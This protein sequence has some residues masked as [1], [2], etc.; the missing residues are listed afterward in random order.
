MHLIFTRDVL[1]H[2]K[3]KTGFIGDDKK[4]FL[5]VILISLFFSLAF[6]YFSILKYF[7]LDS[8]A[9]DLGIHSQ[10]LWSTLHGHMFY[11]PLIG[12]N[13][14]AEHFAPFE[15]V[16]L[17]I[18]LIYPSPISILIFQAVFV[19][20]AA[21]PLYLVSKY[22]MGMG[23]D[24][25]S[26]NLISLALVISFEMSPYVQSP[27]S[28]DFHNI[29]F[30]PFFFFMAIYSFFRR[31]GFL[32]IT[33]LAFIVSLHSNFVYI[34]GSIIL[35]EFIYLRT[36][37]GTDMKSWA[38]R[39]SNKLFIWQISILAAAIA[40]LY[41]YLVF[42]GIMK[43]YFSGSG[44]YSF[45]PSTGETGSPSTSVLG[46]LA[47]VFK[48]PVELF[49][50][51]SSNY[52]YKLFFI[53]FIF[54]LLGMTPFFAP[55]SLITAL[56]YLMYAVPS[57]YASYYELGYQYTGMFVG[58]V[59]LAA[60]FGI[61]NLLK[62]LKFRSVRNRDICSIR[63]KSFTL[64]FII[65][66]AAT[67]SLPLGL[68]PPPHT[69]SS[70]AGS[71]LVS[72]SDLKL[73]NGSFFLLD[74]EKYIPE[75]SYILT[76]NNLMPYFSNYMNAYSTPWSPGILGN[77]SKFQYIVIQ[78]SSM[79]AYQ[80]STSPSLS[81]IVNGVLANKTW[82]VYMSLPASNIT[83]LKKGYSGKPLAVSGL[84]RYAY[85]GNYLGNALG[86]SLL[87][88]ELSTISNSKR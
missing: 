13:F 42:S 33:S 50:F 14:L 17:P 6:S 82:G 43:G 73:N 78:N 4:S 77:M 30:L 80:S 87:N 70:P 59:Y 28:F 44:G 49:V 11:S 84:A 79:W 12:G 22:V 45:F 39:N 53:L 31:R 41:L 18:Y 34:A 16:Q 37:S 46:L 76:Q 5:L 68:F 56:P 52:E 20:F 62:F 32:H 61:P 86:T 23:M 57:N 40:I 71:N 64:A 60:I 19:S 66:M 9:Y 69:S 83:I 88:L 75:D 65:L 27:V 15:F 54:V 1:R 74:S 51:V 63:K 85:N 29:A 55:L 58:P 47:L 25:L 8:S 38:P 48:N 81:S 10:I 26:T 7:S 3:N 36:K 24:K 35:Y 21:V 2:L 72:L 67:L